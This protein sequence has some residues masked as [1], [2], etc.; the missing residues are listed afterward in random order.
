MGFEAVIF[1]F[2]GVFTTSPVLHFAEFERE[3]KLP[4]RFIG[5]VIKS[6][7]HDSAFSRFERGEISLDEFDR[8]FAEETKAAGYEIPGRVL[9]GLLRVKFYPA[10]EGALDKI[11]I[12][13]YKTGCITNNFPALGDHRD[14]QDQVYIQH[15]QQLYTKFDQVIES[16]KVGI[17][18]PEPEIYQMMCQALQVDANNCIFVDDLGINLKPAKAMGMTTVKVPFE[19]ITPAIQEL[20]NLLNLQL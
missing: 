13:G 4:H 5:T 12:A 17:R 14:A 15:A 6:N 18:K 11:K 3:N 1:D 9:A 2:G 10:M 20:E 16:S 7:I 8:Q 19:D